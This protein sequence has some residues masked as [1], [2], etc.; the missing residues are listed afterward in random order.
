MFKNKKLYKVIVR[1]VLEKEIEVL[2]DDEATAK[3]D[4]ESKYNNQKII[5]S[6]NDFKYTDFIIN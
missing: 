5:L 6:E 1:E 3:E 4:V 2:A